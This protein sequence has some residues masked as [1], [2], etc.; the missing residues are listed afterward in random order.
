MISEFY[1]VDANAI[2]VC[3]HRNR[4]EIDSDGTLVKTLKEMK[5]SLQNVMTTRKSNYY[6][7]FVVLE[8]GE[9]AEIPN[10]STY[11]S[12]RAVLRIGMLLRDSEVAKEVRTQPRIDRDGKK[13]ALLFYLILLT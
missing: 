4:A 12:P 7:N 9:S 2:R 5:K 13:F 3:Y 10:K 1:E 11:F 6:Y 8:N